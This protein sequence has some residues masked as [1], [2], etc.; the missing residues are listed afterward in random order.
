MVPVPLVEDYQVRV[1]LDEVVGEA[2]GDL[3]DRVLFKSEL[4]DYDLEKQLRM[5]VHVL[6]GL[7]LWV[8]HVVDE[9]MKRLFVLTP[10]FPQVECINVRDAIRQVSTQ[11]LELTQ[12]V[13]RHAC[14]HTTHQLAV[15][16][17]EEP[18]LWGRNELVF[19]LNDDRVCE[20]GLLNPTPAEGCVLARV[21]G[22][23]LVGGNLLLGVA[24]E[25]NL[26]P[27]LSV[28][29]D[30]FVGLDELEEAF[31]PRCSFEVNEV[32][33]DIAFPVLKYCK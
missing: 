8:L 2:L 11:S 17:K 15:L 19:G 18:A 28:L 25:E 1:L 24:E 26:G 9:P 3:V 12:L 20:S 6:Q 32:F 10:G 27:E 23:L 31:S 33:G 29:Q 5:L 14:R 13:G 21:L 22:Q 4:V 7:Q 16:P 30:A